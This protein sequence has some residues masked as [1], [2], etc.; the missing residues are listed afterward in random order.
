MTPGLDDA[1]RYDVVS[2]YK[3]AIFCLHIPHII[4]CIS[5]PSRLGEV[6]RLMEHLLGHQN[7]YNESMEFGICG[8][9][10]RRAETICLS[11]LTFAGTFS[12][13]P[14]PARCLFRSSSDLA[15]KCRRQKYTAQ[16]SQTL[17]LPS[18]YGIFDEPH[19]RY[20]NHKYSIACVL[21]FSFGRGSETVKLLRTWILELLAHGELGSTQ[22]TSSSV[23]NANVHMEEA[24]LACRI[25]LAC[26]SHLATDR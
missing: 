26:H 22:L 8:F 11:K 23:P 17:F 10:L 3:S 2:G 21:D 5:I 18:R 12:N 9:Y 19:E 7:I 15:R 25:R 20:R 24:L 13:S 16:A 6:L 14:R 1:S 4:H